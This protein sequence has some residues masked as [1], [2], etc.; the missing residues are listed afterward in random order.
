MGQIIGKNSYL[1]TCNMIAC[2]NC[3]V[4]Q[5]LVVE[6]FKDGVKIMLVSLHFFVIFCFSLSKI[7]CP[8]LAMA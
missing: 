8:S 2:E 4:E 5:N 7:Q 6:N 3:R 1:E